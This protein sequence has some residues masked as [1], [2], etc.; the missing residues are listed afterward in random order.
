M[1]VWGYWEAPLYFS[2]GTLA[3]IGVVDPLSR[4]LVI[5]FLPAALLEMVREYG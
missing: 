3:I 2:S 5:M 1:S 4:F